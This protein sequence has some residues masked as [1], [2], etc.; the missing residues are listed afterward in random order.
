[1][2]TYRQQ[3]CYRQVEPHKA[4]NLV[5]VESNQVQPHSEVNTEPRVKSPG[6]ATK[7][8]V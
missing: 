7:L 2:E 5:C 4:L 6:F 3:A 8:A 1:M